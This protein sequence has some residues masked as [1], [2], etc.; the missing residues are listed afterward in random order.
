MTHH[1]EHLRAL[2]DL[3]WC[4]GRAYLPPL[5]GELATAMR[6]DLADDLAAIADELGFACAASIDGLRASLA[7]IDHARLL[8]AY[9]GLFLQPPMRVNL[10]ASAYL[11]GCL[12]GPS[13]NVMEA[14]Y[15]RHGL[16]AADT[17]HDFSD[18]LSRLLEFVGLLFARAAEASD[19]GDRV[20]AGELCAEARAFSARHLRPWLPGFAVEVRHAAADLALPTAY[21]HLAELAAIAVWEGDAW[22]HAVQ[23]ETTLKTDEAAP[24]QAYCVRCGK[25]HA[26]DAALA[27]VRRI[28][29]ARGLD[30]THLDRCPQCRGLSDDECMETRPACEL[31]LESA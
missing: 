10:N 24:A 20:T 19:A 25:P 3:H 14:A 21:Q 23:A 30:T 7:E 28:L 17:L 12:L 9:S 29:A 4:L 11:D 6:E 15:R 2:A 1:S 22:R 13:V 5:D 16:R 27:T 8:Q 31:G 18:H 26:E